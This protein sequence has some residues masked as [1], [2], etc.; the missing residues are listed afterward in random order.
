[1]SKVD[2]SQLHDLY[3]TLIAYSKVL[4][5]KKRNFQ[6][7]RKISNKELAELSN[8]I[9]ASVQLARS[10]RKK[11]ELEDIDLLILDRVFKPKGCD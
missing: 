6:K 3:N 4:D 1:M 5:E 11:I 2:C 10:V 9:Y 7:N 8:L